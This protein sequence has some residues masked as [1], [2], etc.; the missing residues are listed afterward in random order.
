MEHCFK[1][2]I[3]KKH[4]HTQQVFLF[5]LKGEQAAHDGRL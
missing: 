2:N 1:L 5:D 4:T 3:I